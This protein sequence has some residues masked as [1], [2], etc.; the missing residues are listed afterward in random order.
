M[1]NHNP[2]G[3][4]VVITALVD[5]AEVFAE[6]ATWLRNTPGFSEVTQPCWMSRQQR[7]DEHTFDVGKGEGL[8]IEWYA[9]AEHECGAGLSFGLSLVLDGEEW[10]IGSSVRVVDR[11]GE[12]TLVELPTRHAV[13]DDDFVQELMSAASMLGAARDRAASEFKKRYGG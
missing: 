7:R 4:Q 8:E 13:D 1:T 3:A 12:D 6:L 2:A 9:D 11:R 5:V 10:T